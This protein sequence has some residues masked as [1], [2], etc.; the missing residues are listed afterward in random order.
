MITS[1]RGDRPLLDE[2]LGLTFTIRGESMRRSL[3]RLSTV[4][5]AFMTV[6]ANP[7]AAQRVL[8]IGDD[9]LVLPRGV[10]RLRV[11]AQW[12]VFNERYGLNTPGREN[13]S[14]EPLGIDFGLDTIGIREFPNLAAV[15][16]GLR[17][18]TGNPN[19]GLT[20][21]STRVDLRAHVTAIPFVVEARSEEHT[22]ELQSLAYL[23]CRLLLE[24]KK[25][26]YRIKIF[27]HKINK[28]QGLCSFDRTLST[29]AGWYSSAFSN[30]YLRRYK[31]FRRLTSCF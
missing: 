12:A 18:L 31:A 3:V 11:L 16:T 9:A 2:H 28:H 1:P 27:N 15:Q 7:A 26:S 17:A 6:F 4:A 8:G 30:S 19:F 24:K 29:S 13:G 23:V 14:L 25:Y 22:S 20:L 5:L 21:G 10:L